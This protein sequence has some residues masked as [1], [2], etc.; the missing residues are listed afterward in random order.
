M[1]PLNLVGDLVKDLAYAARTLGKVPTFAT[2]VILTIAL[3]IGASTAIFS[4]V[5]AVLLR[6]L[7]YKDPDRLVL[8]DDPV[9]NAYFYDLY[10]G[11]KATFDELAAVMVFRT[12]VPREDGTAERISKGQITTNFFHML[13]AQVI[14]GHDFSEDDGIAKL[15]PPPPFPPSE[16]S[17]AIL[18]YDYFQRRYGGG[19]GLYRPQPS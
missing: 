5:N 8:S 6:P 11:T 14:F 4:V 3:G 9:S 15:P 2:T 17:V 10:D 7:P 1:R 19:S 18:S 13:G 16:G 12:I